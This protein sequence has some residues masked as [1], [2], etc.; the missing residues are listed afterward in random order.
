MSTFKRWISQC[1]NY[2]L[3]KKKRLWW[4][5][6]SALVSALKFLLTNPGN[7]AEPSESPGPQRKGG[8]WP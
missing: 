3:K 8:H 6:I 5:G 1:E 2:V 4:M 7:T